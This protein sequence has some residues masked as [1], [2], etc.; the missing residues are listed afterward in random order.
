MNDP[1]ARQRDLVFKHPLNELA[2]FSLGRA[3]YEAGDL[4]GA[5]ENL[6]VALSLKP[7]WMVV[8]ILLG[9]CSLAEGHL[10]EAKEAFE[11]ALQLAVEQ[12]HQGP[13]EE[14]EDQLSQLKIK[15]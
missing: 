2:R 14:L 15:N 6:D 12:N 4:V 9:K 3:L 8:Q 7:D 11:R 1:F 13:K 5:R 10:I